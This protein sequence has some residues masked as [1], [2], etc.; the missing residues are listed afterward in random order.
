MSAIPARQRFGFSRLAGAAMVVATFVALPTGA[1]AQFVRGG[2][3]GGAGPFRGP[4]GGFG[5]P[6]LMGL[7]GALGGFI[8]APRRPPTVTEVPDD[9]IIYLPNRRH[10]SRPRR[11]KP[12][13]SK[14][15]VVR[16]VLRANSTA[17]VTAHARPAALARPAIATRPAVVTPAGEVPGE[18]LVVLRPGAPADAAAVLARRLGLDRVAAQTF[19]LVPTTIERFRI[20]GQRS[21][22]AV[23]RALTADPL[24]LSAQPN[25]IFTLSGPTTP[26]ALATAQYAIAKLHL[27][28]AHRAATG[29]DVAV[30][31][32][33]S[34]AD[35]SHPALAGAIADSTDLLGSDVTRKADPHGTAIVGLIAARAILDSASP[36]AR[37]MAIRAFAG[38]AGGVAPGASGTTLHVLRAL[39]WAASHGAKI[40]NMSFAGPEDALLSSFLAA[41]AAKGEILVAAAG[42]A[43]PTSPPL[44]PAADPHVLA[45]TATDAD[46][47]LF[48]AANRG[49]Y[50]AVAAPGADMFVAMPGGGYGF[51]SGTSMAA[52]EVSG[53]VALML[54][55]NP[56]LT[57]AAV[58]TALTAS[59]S[60]LTS[61][62]ATE[63]GAGLVDADR[64]LTLLGGSP[65]ADGTVAEQ[66]SLEPP[67]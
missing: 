19:T 8:P 62:G 29:R 6:G 18:I 52:A 3:I 16:P 27:V 24:V 41:G 14:I 17:H 64:A 20:R 15:V 63:A 61:G 45:V 11:P 44:Y 42:N 13:P 67:R 46:N 57:P 1:E 58:R 12:S 43:G 2:G 51:S 39:D 34:W 26:P 49:R 59:A 36:E 54:Q 60:P 10:P 30:A 7:P 38:N 66:P 33:D 4:G 31:V 55:K 40:V 23:V 21:I 37:I 25:H 47:H 9:E 65:P 32:I 28:E 56:D 5:M 22:A 35:P 48:P 50:I 53:I